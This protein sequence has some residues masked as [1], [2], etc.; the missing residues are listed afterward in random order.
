MCKKFGEI[1]TMVFE[2]RKRTDRQ[3]NIQTR[4]SQYFALSNEMQSNNY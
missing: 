1:W 3:S 2:I 4:L